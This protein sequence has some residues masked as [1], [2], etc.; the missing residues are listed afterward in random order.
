M[1]IELKTIWLPRPAHDY[2]GA[3]P[4]GFEN[5]IQDIL[6]TTD[7]VHFF[8]GKAKTGYRIDCN[9]GVCPDL[10]A[11]V[12]D[13][14]MIPDGH[15]QAGIADPPYTEEFARDLY[16]TKYPTWSK[17]SRELARV[18]RPGGKIAVM[19]NYIVPKIPGCEYEKIIVILTRI[20]QYPKIVTVQRV[21]K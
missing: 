18:V 11:D 15:F 17:W 10:V 2:P 5:M 16:G 1:A 3:Y 12:H 19:H 4:R 20:K 13:L 14:H 6:D 9:P 7:Y 8:A 21:V